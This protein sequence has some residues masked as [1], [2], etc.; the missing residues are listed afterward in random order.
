LRGT[1]KIYAD[2]P[3]THQNVLISDPS[4][5]TGLVCAT[6][7][8]N[9]VSGLTALDIDYA[10]HDLGTQWQRSDFNGDGIVDT[11]DLNAQTSMLFG[12]SLNV[13]ASPFCASCATPTRTGTWGT[14]KLLYR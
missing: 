8:E 10:S 12:G 14:L 4:P 11:T 13:S 2:D 6:P 5:V 1:V 9:G 7:D 3:V